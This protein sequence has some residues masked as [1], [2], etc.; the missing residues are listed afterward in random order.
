[1]VLRELVGKWLLV[2]V[3][4]GA[5]CGLIA[6]VLDFMLLW[7]KDRQQLWD[8]IAGTIVVDDP[9]DILS[10]DTPAA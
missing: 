7:D 3:V 1:M 5:I 8:K 9:N 4:I 2:G 10:K 6:L